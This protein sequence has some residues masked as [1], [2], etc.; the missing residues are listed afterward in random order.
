MLKTSKNDLLNNYAIIQ[1]KEH[2]LND[3][4]LNGII[5]YKNQTDYVDV[6]V[7]NKNELPA[8]F[9]KKNFSIDDITLLLMKG[10]NYERTHF[11]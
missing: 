8:K 4:R 6:L 9:H 10:E 3:L 5:A 2:E 7:S 1:C 11:K